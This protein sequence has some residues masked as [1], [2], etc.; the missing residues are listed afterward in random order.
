[1]GHSEGHRDG[2]QA[3]AKVF[4]PGRTGREHGERKHALHHAITNL[5]SKTG[6]IALKRGT[7]AS[8]CPAIAY[9][10]HRIKDVALGEV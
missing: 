8:G 3:L 7:P 2:E 4:R 6:S 9:R 1:M 10:L 5:S